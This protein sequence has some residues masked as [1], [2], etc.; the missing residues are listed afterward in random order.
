M[1]V[2]HR[3]RDHSFLEGVLG[4]Y[5][6]TRGKNLADRHDVTLLLDELRKQKHEDMK[7]EAALDIMRAYGTLLQASLALFGVASDRNLFQHRLDVTNEMRDKSSEKHD[8]AYQKYQTAMTTFW[9]LEQIAR[10]IF[11][12]SIC[13]K[14]AVVKDAFNEFTVE[15][16]Q[17]NTKFTPLYDAL[18]K[19][20]EELSI[21]IKAELQI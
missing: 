11:P 7:R 10:L 20:Q 19:K 16:Y 14:M 5:G 18:V 15:T 12:Q 1:R 13:E 9:Q 8:V 2:A 21:A 17:N 4:S 6:Q 3:E